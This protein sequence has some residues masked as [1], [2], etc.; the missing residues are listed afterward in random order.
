MKLKADALEAWEMER[1]HNSRQTDFVAKEE[2]FKTQKLNELN[3]LK[4]RIQTG[5]DEQK[6][7]RQ[8]DLDR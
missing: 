1:W 2:K 3:A 8:Q 5:R 6:I 7:T 4:K